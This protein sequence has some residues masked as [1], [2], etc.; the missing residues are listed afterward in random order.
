MQDTQGILY[1]QEFPV[2]HSVPLSLTPSRANHGPGLPA[3]KPHPN[4]L[5]ALPAMTIFRYPLF[6][7]SSAFDDQFAFLS[8]AYLFTDSGTRQC[9]FQSAPSL[10]YPLPVADRPPFLAA[11]VPTVRS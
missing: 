5:A 8:V 6:L 1:G 9:R 10:L 2:I 4:V 7:L 11:L 3:V